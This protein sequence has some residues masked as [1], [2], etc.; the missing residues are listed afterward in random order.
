[1]SPKLKT[2]IV[3]GNP[4]SVDTLYR[5]LKVANPNIEICGE[6][7]SINEAVT[8]IERHNPDAIFIQGI[9]FERLQNPKTQKKSKIIIPIAQNGKEAVEVAKITYFEAKGQCTLVHLVDG[10]YI[11]AFRILGYFK[12]LLADDA[13]FYPIHH[14]LFVNVANVKSFRS[15]THEVV[16]SNGVS[17]EASRRLSTGF[18][19]FW[20][21]F[22]THTT[23]G[24]AMSVS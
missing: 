21:A 15:K 7:S 12:K 23:K 3:E 5:S 13:D 4:M 10:S 2:I 24:E 1:M 14:A 22:N 17:L 18:K 6:A 20:N 16:L 9:L 8:L 19:A 11:T